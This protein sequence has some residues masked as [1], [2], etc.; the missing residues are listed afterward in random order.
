L[1]SLDWIFLII[2]TFAAFKGF[3]KGFILE[4]ISI[5]ALFIGVLGAL[6][7]LDYGKEFIAKRLEINGDILPYLSFLLIFILIVII[8]NL[9]GRA[10]KKLV[11]LTLLGGLDDIAGAILGIFK[12]SL[13]VSLLIWAASLIQV[14]LPSDW[15]EGS[16]I[17]PYLA[18]FAPNLFNTLS[19]IFPFIKDL[20]QYFSL[21]I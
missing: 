2:L 17:Y 10:I 21:G 6:K 15:T 1:N 20:T 13:I 5:L 9:V 3:R 11:D 12:W 7:L 19:S 14:E 4:I 8:L 16:M 18:W